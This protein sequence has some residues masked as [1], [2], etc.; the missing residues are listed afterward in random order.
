LPA[1]KLQPNQHPPGSARVERLINH[2]NR[3]L[4]PL[5]A[6]LRRRATKSKRGRRAAC[7]FSG[8]L[9]LSQRGTPFLGEQVIEAIDR[10]IG[11]AGD[12]AGFAN[13]EVYQYLEGDG[14][15]TPFSCRPISR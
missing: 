4:T 10:M 6:N 3:P 9:G 13:P 15:K 8:G 7:G 1:K 12:D 11:D 5:S 14:S 2:V